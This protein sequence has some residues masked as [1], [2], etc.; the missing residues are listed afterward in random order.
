MGQYPKNAAFLFIIPKNYTLCQT[1]WTFPMAKKLIGPWVHTVFPKDW[2]Q[3]GSS[4][5]HGTENQEIKKLL[6]F[7]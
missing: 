1:L 7:C 4:R 5:E 3:H 6:F 2:K